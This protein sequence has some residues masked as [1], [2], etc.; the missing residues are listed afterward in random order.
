MWDEEARDPVRRWLVWW[1]VGGVIVV[2]IAAGIWY[3]YFYA[4]SAP[5]PAPVVQQP[6]PAAAPETGPANPLPPETSTTALPA[7]NDSDQI[8]ADSLAG[9]LG[10][11]TVAQFL[12]PQSIVRHIVVTVDNLPGKKVAV[13]LRPV[14][15][16][17][18]RRPSRPRAIRSC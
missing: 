4:A 2:A 7:L 1:V 14:K 3:R 13:D 18:G 9:V 17:R 5:A 10:H 6:A 12:V 15:P 11:P 16:T 8:V